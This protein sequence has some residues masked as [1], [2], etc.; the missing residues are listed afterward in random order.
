MKR[1]NLSVIFWNNTQD[2]SRSSSV[3]GPPDEVVWCLR[4]TFECGLWLTEQ[5]Y[6][7][8]SLVATAIIATALLPCCF[9]STLYGR[10]E[11]WPSDAEPQ[12]T[13]R[14]ILLKSLTIQISTVHPSLSPDRWIGGARDANTWHST[15]PKRWWRTTW[16]NREDV[17]L[18]WDFCSV[19]LLLK[20]M[21]L[22]KQY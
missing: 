15:P 11:I 7:G 5:L 22:I 2:Y 4:M 21:Y 18:G 19:T 13:S 12:L 20:V 3:P 6:D 1:K 16:R 9:L 8:Q 14:C 17:H 10:L